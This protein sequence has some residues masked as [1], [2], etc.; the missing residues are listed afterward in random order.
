MHLLTKIQFLYAIPPT[1]A[2]KKDCPREEEKDKKHK[3]KQEGIKR[4]ITCKDAAT[5]LSP[6]IKTSSSS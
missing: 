3:Q 6:D 5:Q 2:T 1:Q 4:E